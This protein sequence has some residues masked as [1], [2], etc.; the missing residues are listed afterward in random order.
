ML[1][2]TWDVVY[3]DESGNK[4]IINTFDNYPDAE[5]VFRKCM[6]GDK[7]AQIN[8]SYDIEEGMTGSPGH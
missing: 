2:K 8:Q 5:E 7:E 1:K 6:E 4:E 3:W